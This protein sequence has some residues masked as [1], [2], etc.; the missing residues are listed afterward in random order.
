MATDRAVTDLEAVFGEIIANEIDG[1]VRFEVAKVS[2][3][4]LEQGLELLIEG[5]SF[6]R[7]PTRLR[8]TVEPLDAL[9]LVS[10]ESGAHGL[11][12]ALETLGDLRDA[13]SLAVEQDIVAALGDPRA[14]TASLFE[15]VVL[16]G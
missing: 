2:R 8:G 6:G 14:M 10:L 15:L 4:K 9:A 7:R 16:V 3:R 12:I 11:L 1:P 5:L 13:Q